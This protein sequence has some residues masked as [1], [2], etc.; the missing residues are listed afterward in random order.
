MRRRVLPPL[1]D[2]ILQ[3]VRVVEKA[4]EEH[5]AETAERRAEYARMAESLDRKLADRETG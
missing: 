3:A 2:P 1:R 4:L 5:E